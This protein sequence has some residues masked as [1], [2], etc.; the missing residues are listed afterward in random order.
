MSE[1]A[2]GQKKGEKMREITN[3][4][5]NEVESEYIG[6]DIYTIA[7]HALS[8]NTISSIAKVNEQ[9]EFTRNRFSIDLKTL[10]VTNQKA[11][12]RCW[13]FAGC[14]IL[15]EV[16]AKKYDLKEFELSQNYVAFY[17]KLEKCN[18]L[19]E[20]LIELR[21][22]PSE[23]RTLDTLLER[24]IED[25]GQW[26]LFVNIVKKYGVVP[27]DAFPET[28]Q[29]S[30]TKEI[31]NLLNKY[32]RKFA[33]E[34]KSI[35]NA[36]E[37]NNKKSEIMKNIY[38]ML[39]SSFGVPPKTISFEYVNKAKEYN[40]IKNITPKEF[41][42]KYV[43]I[44]LD[45]YVS[46]INSPTKDKPY[47]E[48]YTV[49]YLGNVIEGNKVK[50]LNLEMNRLKEL[51]INQLKS[52]QPVWFGSDCSKGADRQ[53][54][55]WDDLS[56]DKDI[57][58]QINTKMSKEAMLDTRESAMNHAMVI[59]GVNLEDEKP[60]KWKIENSWG[61]E[62]ANKGYYVA[63]DSWFDKFVYQAVIHKKYLSETEK[64][65]LEKEPKKLEIWDP[66][67]TLA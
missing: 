61:E 15:R 24:G 56:F 46:I 38:K 48:T 50:Y 8:K 13:I 12:G 43:E 59:T 55:V 9:T 63:T 36:E 21:N 14:N 3:N 62:V 57:L 52:G 30:N 4:F 45:E 40:I 20:S 39:C 2:S 23:E 35:T 26:D 49:K 67:G 5:I 29:S 65:E 34:I 10:P 17:D 28:F 6:N 11:S 18:Y 64:S 37:I 42:E 32:V 22:N 1:I 27:K 19:M 31:D 53:E 16:I 25:G 33:F 41:L 47:N 44:D 58:F 66:M 54:G 60:T 7:R 51:I